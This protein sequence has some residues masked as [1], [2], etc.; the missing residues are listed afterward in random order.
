MSHLPDDP[1]R[2]D[3]YRIMLDVRVSGTICPQVVT[4][5]SFHYLERNYAGRHAQVEVNCPGGAAAVVNVD[6]VS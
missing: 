4:S 2:P 5:E 3:V 1:A 6:S